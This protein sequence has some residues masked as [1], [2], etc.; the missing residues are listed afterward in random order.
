M[1]LSI[2][3]SVCVHINH[4]LFP[5]GDDYFLVEQ[6]GL[7]FFSYG[8]RYVCKYTTLFGFEEE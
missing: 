8:P 6:D 7:L 4:S 5:P 1:V 3:D 2:N